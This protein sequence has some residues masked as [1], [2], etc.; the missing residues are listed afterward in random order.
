M[1][2]TLAQDATL[3]REDERAM[4]NKVGLRAAARLQRLSSTKESGKEALLWHITP[5][6]QEMQVL[7]SAASSVC[8]SVSGG[9]P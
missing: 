1:I 4:I 2:S 9:R 8:G 5:Q 3:K 6:R 7:R